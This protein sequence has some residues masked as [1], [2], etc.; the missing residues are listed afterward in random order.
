M[1]DFDN[2]LT[3]EHL[4][5]LNEGLERI[6]KTENLIKASERS[7]IMHPGKLDELMERR[8]QINQ[9]KANFFPGQ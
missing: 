9:L 2:P 7:G 6:T 5:Q 3:G 4:A 1:A 8:K